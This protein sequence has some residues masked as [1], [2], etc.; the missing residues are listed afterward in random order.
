MVEIK[1]GNPC[2]VYKQGMVR[3]YI[4]LVIVI[5]C[6]NFR[7]VIKIARLGQSLEGEVY[8]I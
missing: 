3:C 5:F 6:N 7:N 2:F 4:E 1:H 8:Q